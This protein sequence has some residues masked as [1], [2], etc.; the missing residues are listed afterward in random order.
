LAFYLHDGVPDAAIMGASSTFNRYGE[1]KNPVDGNC[2]FAVQHDVFLQCISQGN[3]LSGSGHRSGENFKRG[4]KSEKSCK[5]ET[6]MP[7]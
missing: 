6:L 7:T 5:N 1:K 3:R 4:S 2:G